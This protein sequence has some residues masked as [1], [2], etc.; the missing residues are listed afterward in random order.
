MADFSYGLEILV[1]IANLLELD[2][3][4][5]RSILDWYNTISLVK[6]R[7]DYNTFGIINKGD[8]LNFYRE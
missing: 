3:P 5:M 6:E 2:T 4:Y 1:Q 8:L 7:F